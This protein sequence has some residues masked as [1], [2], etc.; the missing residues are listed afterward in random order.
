MGRE[1]RP[2]PRYRQARSSSQG[3]I[4]IKEPIWSLVKKRSWSTRRLLEHFSYFYPP[5]PVVKLAKRMGIYVHITDDDPG[6]AGAIISID[7]RADIWLRGSDSL[8]RR[9]FTL[10]HEIGHLM[11]HEL[12]TEFRD[13]TFTDRRGDRVEAQANGY[14][15]KLLMPDFMLD[16][17]L[18]RMGRLDIDALADRYDVSEVAMKIRVNNFLAR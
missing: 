12:G 5:V 9:R 18:R 3:A 2:K 7:D 16:R 1:M 15:A 10:A 11:L 8:Q 14:A 4:M 17:D 6:W 13:I